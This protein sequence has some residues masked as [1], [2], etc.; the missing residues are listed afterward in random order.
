[1]KKIIWTIAAKVGK[2]K[3]AA[4]QKQL[5]YD[6][7]KRRKGLKLHEDTPDARTISKILKE[8][9]RLDVDVLKADLPPYVW[10]LRSDYETIVKSEAEQRLESAKKLKLEVISS[11]HEARSREQRTSIRD[12]LGAFLLEG[13]NIRDFESISTINT[14]EFERKMV[15]WVDKVAGYIE[16]EFDEAE[17]SIFLDSSGLPPRFSFTEEDV[18][19]RKTVLTYL[20]FRLQRLVELIGK[21]QV[22]ADKYIITQNSIQSLSPKLPLELVKKEQEKH[23]EEVEKH[24]IAIGQPFTTFGGN[25]EVDFE[26]RVTYININCTQDMTEV[27]HSHL[28]DGAFWQNVDEYN[29]KISKANSIRKELTEEIAK[30]ATSLAPFESDWEYQE[31]YVTWYFVS[32]VIDIGIGKVIPWMSRKYQW[33]EINQVQT[34]QARY[35][36]KGFQSEIEHRAIAETY[37]KD[38]RIKLLGELIAELEKLKVGILARLKNAVTDKEYKYYFCS[39]CPLVR[40]GHV[41]L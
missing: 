25:I 28:A 29:E 16:A 35:I 41:K 10:K 1:M 13:Q 34:Y 11:S 15:A 4:I 30:A 7:E 33:D 9:D 5:E 24:L 18:D 27:L 14:K 37:S 8:L 39:K 3:M 38:E 21:C 31:K 17:K 23:W 26:G 2:D 22:I 36:S 32:S 20:G 40:S 19:G 6:L 12:T